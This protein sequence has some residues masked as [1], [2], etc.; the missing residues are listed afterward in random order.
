[1]PLPKFTAEQAR[2]MFP[3]VHEFVDR[4]RGARCKH[5]LWEPKPEENARKCTMS[6]EAAPR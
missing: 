3:G 1:M 4:A 5:C 2:T 6:R